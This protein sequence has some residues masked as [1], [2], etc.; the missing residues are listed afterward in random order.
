MS[1][2]VKITDPEAPTAM[3]IPEHEMAV[4]ARALPQLL[5]PVLGA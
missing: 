2:R 5:P 4:E 1:C 3:K